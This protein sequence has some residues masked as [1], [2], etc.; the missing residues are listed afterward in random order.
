M[1]RLSCSVFGFL[2]APSGVILRRFSNV[3]GSR[4]RQRL[5]QVA[6][7][8]RLASTE[9]GEN[10]SGHIS[11]GPN[12]GILFFDNI[13]PLRLRIA[14]RLP[15]NIAEI[16]K[17]ANETAGTTADPA[18]I[19][20][21]A[22]P[23][24]ASFK[25]TNVLPRMK[26]GGAF[27][28]FSHGQ[29]SSTVEIEASVRKYLKEHP[30]KPWFSPFRPVRTFLVRG[31]PWLEDLYRFPTS[32]LKVEFIPRA[33]VDAAAE[34]PQEALYALFRRY[35]KLGDIVPQPADSK[36][37][38]KFAYLNFLSVGNA[39]MAKNCMHGFRVLEADGGTKAGIELRLAYERINK[40]HW[41]RD[42]LFNHPRIVIPAAAALIATITV[43]VFDPVRTWFV[44]AHITHSLQLTDSKIWRW[45]KAQATDIFKLKD[46]E[47]AGL[48]AIW[49]DR[50]ECIEQIQ[51]WLMET[52]ET[53][54]VVQGPRGS[55][56]RELVVDQV[57]KDR[58]HKLVIDCKPIQ[59]A[60]GDSAKIRAAAAGVGYRPVFSWM[61]SISSLIDL[62]AQGAIGTKAGFSETLDTQL[63]KI[64]Q[65][66]AIALTRIALEERKKG[67]KDFNLG[68]DE[69]LEAHPEKRPVVVI[70]NFLHKHEEGSPVYNK[71]SEWAAALV[72]TNVAHV[73]F[74]THD[75]AFPKSLS[76]ALPDRVFRT[77]SLGD[78]T[79]EA[80]KRLV[81]ARLDA[82]DPGRAGGQ[83]KELVVSQREQHLEELDECIGILGGRLTDLEFLARR[84]KTGETPKKAMDGIIEQSASEILKMYLLDAGKA[85]RK[86]SPEQAWL[87]IK[88]LAKS[89]SLRYNEIL[90]TDTFKPSPSGDGGG[91]PVLQ[92]LEQAELITIHSEHGRPHSIRP[93]KPVYQAA[94]RLLTNDRVLTSHLDLATLTGLIKLENASIEKYEG[95]LGVLG[96]LPGRPEG[97]AGRI[98][99]LVGKIEGAQRRIEG[100]EREMAGLRKVLRGE[101]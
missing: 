34:V 42:W 1:N 61:N 93:G 72:T 96:Q 21:E 30:I 90:L 94:F 95:E 19:I 55:G 9:A 26:D 35:G 7:G 58:K 63:A 77:V 83:A 41:I 46:S 81:L 56:K 98:R 60:R 38:P 84:M 68:N 80:A 76:K 48:N 2:A 73:V 33:P 45:F 13:L 32:R 6:R 5:M 51:A 52:S 39:I 25:I 74:L 31:R 85:Q 36:I 59:E 49:D 62:A 65:N 16:L 53:F 79:P 23:S 100:Y 75:V 50:K 91:D 88:E 71:I 15:L 86:W 18:S 70:D 14:H 69:Y 37:L 99:W 17:G 28:K 89:E 66:T 29:E 8:R 44:K 4:S 20:R 97:L 24:D 3:N 11:A 22:V 82:Y 57:L 87:L 12:E 40:T 27:V 47:E 43:A 78:C 54:I 67:D 92:A 101:Y 10:E 64:W